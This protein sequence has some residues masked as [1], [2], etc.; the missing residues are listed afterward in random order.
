MDQVSLIARLAPEDVQIHV[1]AH[2]AK[3]AQSC[4]HKLRTI[5]PNIAQSSACDFCAFQDPRPPSL[6]VLLEE[7]R[8][9][10]LAPRWTRDHYAPARPEI[11]ALI[12]MLDKKPAQIQSHQR[13][14]HLLPPEKISILRRHFFSGHD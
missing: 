3:V 5:S 14:L 1:G 11:S 9:Q 8:W 6:R 12:H 13:S 2:R 10:V 7:F 4:Q